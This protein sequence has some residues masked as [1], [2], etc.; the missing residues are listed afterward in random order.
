MKLLATIILVILI[1][2]RCGAQQQ[3]E[4]I[5]LEQKVE[6]FNKMKNTGAAFTVI[7]SILFVAGVITINNNP[8]DLFGDGSGGFGTGFGLFVLGAAGL[9]SG[10]T[11]WSVGAHNERKYKSQLQ[12]ISV[13]AN[14]G[15]RFKGIGVVYRF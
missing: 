13:T 8:P 12:G 3:P 2:L 14:L 15:Q 9:G 4:K 10:I 6:K 1:S 5:Q 7:G 11:L